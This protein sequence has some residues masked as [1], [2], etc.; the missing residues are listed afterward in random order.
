MKPPEEIKKGLEGC[1]DKSNCEWC[2]LID[3]CKR[4]ADALAYIEQLEHA[5]EFYGNTNQMLDAKIAKLESRLAQVERERDALSYD[6]HQ[7]QGAICAYCENLYRPDG[8]EHV[9]C[10]VF[11][12]DYG[13]EDGSPLICGSFKWRGVC[14]ENTKEKS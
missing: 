11:G 9:A 5:V 10:K 6:M 14:A 3:Q 4:N 13:G 8:A 7:L 2:N 12:K 1:K